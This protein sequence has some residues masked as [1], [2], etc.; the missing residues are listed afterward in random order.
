M[1]SIVWLFLDLPLLCIC[2]ELRDNCYSHAVK[3]FAIATMN[4]LHHAYPEFRSFFTAISK[5]Q[6]RK[7]GHYILL[8]CSWLEVAARRVTA[9]NC[10]SKIIIALQL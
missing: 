9:V 1:N 2:S 8:M 4:V 7:Q 10:F 3:M 6:Y 5:W